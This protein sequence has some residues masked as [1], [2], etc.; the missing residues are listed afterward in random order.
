MSGITRKDAKDLGFLDRDQAVDVVIRLMDERDTLVLACKR[1]LAE[2]E[3]PAEL[4]GLI[5]TAVAK[6]EG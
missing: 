3:V 6:A 1:V 5:E 2:V 4:R